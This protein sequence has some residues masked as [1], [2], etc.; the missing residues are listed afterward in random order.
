MLSAPSTMARA[1]SARFYWNEELTEKLLA[2]FPRQL[3]KASQYDVRWDI[4]LTQTEATLG[5]YWRGTNWM[6]QA[7]MKLRAHLLQAKIASSCTEIGDIKS[8]VTTH[9]EV[10]GSELLVG[11]NNNQRRD[12][13]LHL[14]AQL[15]MHKSNEQQAALL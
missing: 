1:M 13:D 10:V 7:L 2:T 9:K 3:A 12:G 6:G 15:F 11:G 8:I 14:A 5:M 4:G